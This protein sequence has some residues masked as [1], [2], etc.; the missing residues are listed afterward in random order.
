MP[1]RPTF[2]QF[3]SDIFLQSKYHFNYG[4]ASYESLGPHI[5][6]IC[7]VHGKIQ[8]DIRAHKKGGGCKKCSLVSGGQKHT[9]KKLIKAKKIIKDKYKGNIEVDYSTF[10]SARNKVRAV[11]DAHGEFFTSFTQLVGRHKHGCPNCA[12]KQRGAAK[13]ISEEEIIKRITEKF[14]YKYQVKETFIKKEA[15]WITVICKEHGEFQ[16]R[17]VSFI[18]NSVGCKKCA[19]SSTG[20]LKR[21]TQAEVIDKLEKKYPNKFD[22][23]LVEFKNIR[24]AIKL[25]CIE[26]K[27]IFEMTVK[28]L[29]NKAVIYACPECSPLKPLTFEEFDEVASSITADRYIFIEDTYKGLSK[30]V[31]ACCKEHKIIFK[32][33]ADSV[34]KFGSGCPLCENSHRGGSWAQ[35]NIAEALSDSDI[36]FLYNDRKTLEGKEIDIH[37]PEHN[38]GIEYNGL[39]WHSEE[40]KDVKDAKWH[41]LNK[42][43][44]GREKEIFIAHFDSSIPNHKIINYALFR[45]GKIKSVYGRKTKVVDVPKS[46]AVEFY[47]QYHIQGAAKGCIY[48]GL[49]YEGELAAVIAFSRANSERGNKD[50]NRWELRRLAFK[51]SVVGGASK[52]FKHFLRNHKEVTSIISYSDNRWFDGKVYGILGFELVKESG[53]DYAYTKNGK[54]FHKAQFRHAVMKTRKNFNYD[55]KMTEAE[56]TKANR[57]YKIW[58]CGKKKWEYTVNG[59]SE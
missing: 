36:N 16:V 53:P 46:T 8:L 56:N 10:T 52:L 29:L 27:N 43:L 11:C 7:P 20:E 39:Y 25:R 42:Q 54:L 34:L 13:R 38:L 37:L 5:S 24:T 6:A 59:T 17:A 15:T 21:L 19:D 58:D 55:A 49:E 30:E 9:Y 45:C 28:D 22:Y 12:A 50:P 33:W 23:S 44:M 31:S 18:K 47:D 48:Y 35:R 32:V 2:N 14:G 4:R 26:H 57:F 40:C 41:M 3:I 1:P 51:S